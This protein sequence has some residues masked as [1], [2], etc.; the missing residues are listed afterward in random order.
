MLTPDRFNGTEEYNRLGLLK[1][2]LSLAQTN[3]WFL[4]FGVYKGTSLKYM[5]DLYPDRI[6]HGFDSFEGLPED[7]NR[8]DTST[9]KKGHFSVSSIPKM[10]SNAKLIKGFF[11]AS[12]PKW[13]EAN[14][15]KDQFV[16]FL[17]IDSDLYSSAKTILTEL[18]KY[19]KAG[20]IIV[21][22]ELCDW[23]ET[24]I[25]PKWERGE[26]LALSEWVRD[27]N[28]SYEVIGRERTFGGAINVC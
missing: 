11:D 13:I 24:N 10:N 21:F 12:L 25:Y 9:Y 27:Y 28:R 5:S 18:N 8:S 14:K 26:W 6:F 7:W 15:N 19:I 16:S 2:S 20:T 17:H 4:E 23:K 1:H 22:D 3:G